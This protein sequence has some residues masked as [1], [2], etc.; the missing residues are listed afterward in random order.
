[1]KSLVYHQIAISQTKGPDDKEVSVDVDHIIPQKAFD[2][3][4]G[5][6][7]A[8]LLK[9][10]LFNLCVLP[11]KENIKKS[12]KFLNEV[13]G[14]WL[15]DYIIQVTGIKQPEFKNYSSVLKWKDL[16]SKRRRMVEEDFIENRK[17]ILN[18]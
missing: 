6:K 7:D 10:S 15:V 14:Q 16:R 17:K 3:S 9:H 8:E 2:T 4:S 12:D 1:M 11:K 18:N 13:K 5:I